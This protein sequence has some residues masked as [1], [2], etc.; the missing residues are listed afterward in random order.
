MFNFDPLVE[1]SMMFSGG[2]IREH[3][4]EMGYILGFEVLCEGIG[5]FLTFWSNVPLYNP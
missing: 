4:V 5:S 3:C 1:G 2:I